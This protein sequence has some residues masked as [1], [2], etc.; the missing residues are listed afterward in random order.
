MTGNIGFGTKALT[1]VLYLR[2]MCIESDRTGQFQRTK[3]DF[4]IQPMLTKLFWENQ[5][6]S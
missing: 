1:A 6:G 2:M 4:K 3:I 5:P